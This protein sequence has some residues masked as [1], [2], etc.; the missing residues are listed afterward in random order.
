[1]VALTVGVAAYRAREWVDR[2]LA[3][4]RAQTL[5]PDQFEVLFVVNGPDDGTAD[6]LLECAAREAFDL[7]VIQFAEG[8]N[9]KARNLGMWAARGDYLVW[10]DS[11]DSVSPNLRC[12]SLTLSLE[13]WS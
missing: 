11:D 4:L 13:T 3:A 7:R 8:S 5:D 9:S 1:M 12:S 10:V 6:Y 2:L